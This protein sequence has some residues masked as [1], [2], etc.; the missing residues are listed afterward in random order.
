MAAEPEPGRTSPSL[1]VNDECKNDFGSTGRYSA[2]EPCSAFALDRA[3]RYEIVSTGS[4]EQPLL[5]ESTEA[6]G[7]SRIRN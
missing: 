4:A 7:G 5:R 6:C 2:P 1:G 3:D